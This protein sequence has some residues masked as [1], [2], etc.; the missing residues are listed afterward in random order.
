[1]NNATTTKK[2][3][4]RL[5]KYAGK[6]VSNPLALRIARDAVIR[7]RDAYPRNSVRTF[8]NGG[9]NEDIVHKIQQ[10]CL[11][12]FARFDGLYCENAGA[13]L[14]GRKEITLVQT[15]EEV[16]D[17][18]FRKGKWYYAGDC[19]E[20]CVRCEDHFWWSNSKKSVNHK[21][22]LVIDSVA[23]WRR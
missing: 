4:N 11:R 22:T 23:A 19:F 16:F 1:M 17:L 13:L 8:W 12:A 20:I 6:A 18:S 15:A 5:A 9:D 10:T 14:E 2:P 7:T 21:R 3:H